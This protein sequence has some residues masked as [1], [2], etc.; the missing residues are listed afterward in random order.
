[1]AK[2]KTDKKKT[3]EVDFFGRRVGTQG[4]LIDTKLSKKPKSPEQ[5]SKETKLPLARIK[6]HVRFYAKKGMLVVKD[7][8]Y[9]LKK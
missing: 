6:T 9:S 4:H 7:G 8:K 5:L 3:A 1:M 2:K